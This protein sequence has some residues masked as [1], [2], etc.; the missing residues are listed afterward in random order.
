MEHADTDDRLTDKELAFRIE[1]VF[2]IK[3]MMI[4]YEQK[5]GRNRIL[6]AALKVKGASIR[7]LS[8]VTGV[9]VNVIWKLANG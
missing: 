1:E 9:S 4:Q 8:R 7:Q 3:A 6:S 2:R 5:E